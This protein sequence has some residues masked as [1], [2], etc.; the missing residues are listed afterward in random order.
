MRVGIVAGIALAVLISLAGLAH[1]EAFDAAR[2][3]NAY[4]SSVSA[5]M[6]ARAS[7]YFER[8]YILD[9]I[10]ASASIVVAL[11]IV[12]TGAARRIRDFA[13]GLTPA[14]AAQVFLCALIFLLVM[15]LAL[16]PVAY[17]RSFVL[18]HEFGL[19]EQPRGDWMLRHAALAALLV[20]LFSL[21]AVAVYAF[22]RRLPN[23]WWLPSA[24]VATLSAAVVLWAAP[25]VAPL[26]DVYRPMSAGP[27]K[28]QV[29]ALAAANGIAVQDIDRVDRSAHSR[30]MDARVVD[31][32]GVARVSFAGTLL[33]RG[34]G[35]EVRHI[36]GQAIGHRVLGHR[37]Q[38]LIL[39]ALV[40]L[41]VLILVARVFKG[42]VRTDGAALGLSDAADAAGLPLLFALLVV[43]AC[44]SAPA[45]KALQRAQDLAADAFALNA[46]R[47][48]DGLAIAALREAEYAKL[49]PGWWEELLFSTRAPAR[50]RIAMAMRWKAQHLGELPVPGFEV[51]IGCSPDELRSPAADVRW[52]ADGTPESNVRV[53]VT[54]TKTGFATG[55][56]ASIVVSEAGRALLFRAEALPPALDLTLDPPARRHVDLDP[57]SP[58]MFALR[59]GNLEPGVLYLWRVVRS[60]GGVSETVRTETSSCPADTEED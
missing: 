20:L 4:L 25:L 53:D 57:T 32:F 34:S 11:L 37:G 26:V 50:A 13:E 16:A 24:A 36:A 46:A 35:M 44:V 52:V 60:E 41:I 59:A 47:E 33:D 28:E 23:G 42:F 14:R 48:P 12:I 3:T 18:D 55:Q 6:Q 1:A 27:I 51:E 29:R 31:M 21:L 45:I 30:R 22:I 19:S 15:A 39:F 9:V 2:A 7:V 56:F 5:D 17:Y 10:A 54:V 40:W 8:G 58:L 43:G 49:D 38:G